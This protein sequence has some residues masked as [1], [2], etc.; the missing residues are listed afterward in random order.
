MVVLAGART[1]IVEIVAKPEL[2]GPAGR[3]I[4]IY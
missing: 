3:H 4:Y 2:F 1:R